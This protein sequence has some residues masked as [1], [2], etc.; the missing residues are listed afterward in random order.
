MAELKNNKTTLKK[1]LN[2]TFYVVLTIVFIYAIFGLF[3]NKK[4]N[5]VSFFGV[6]SMSVL[7]PSMSG[8]FEKG[9]LIFVN[10]DINPRD[11]IEGDIITFL[12]TLDINGEPVSAYNT[13]RIDYIDKSGSVWLFYTKGDANEE[14]DFGYVLESEVYGEY[15]GK[16][17]SGFGSFVEGFTGFLKSSLG[18]FLFIVVPCL[19]LLVYEVIK[20][21]KVYAEYNVQKSKEDRVKMQ[22]E[23][24]AA[25]RAQLEAEAQ[26]K[27][28]KDN[29]DQQD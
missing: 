25:A 22:E 12:D 19:A 26:L 20:F 10:T 3:S 4:L 6:T 16:S 2:I 11:L 14:A 28:E 23:A 9:D 29:K 13:H 27:A 7:T 15:T 8:T 5:S 21:M 1:T 24:L 18:F 17:I